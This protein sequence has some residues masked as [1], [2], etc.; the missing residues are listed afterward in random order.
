MIVLNSK[1]LTWLKL[2]CQGINIWFKIMLIISN[3]PGDAAHVY[4]YHRNVKVMLSLSHITSVLQPLD[5]GVMTNFK[6][7]YI[8]RTFRVWISL[9]SLVFMY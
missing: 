3:T 4:S 5:Q 8:R 9:D 1:S 6:A 7:S 2:D